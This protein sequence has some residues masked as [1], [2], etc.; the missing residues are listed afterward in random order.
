MHIAVT[1]AES[2]GLVLYLDGSAAGR[3][4]GPLAIDAR[5]T[6]FGFLLRGTPPQWAGALSPGSIDEV[7]IY[8]APLESGDIQ[9]LAHRRDPEQS[10]ALPPLQWASRFGWSEASG[11]PTVSKLKA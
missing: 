2:A 7:R 10:P 3:A 4:P 6:F 8:R 1:W 9:R 5:L 11:I